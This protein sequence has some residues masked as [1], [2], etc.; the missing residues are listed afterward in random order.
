MT[1]RASVRYTGSNETA[2]LP[3]AELSTLLLLFSP[4]VLLLLLLLMLEL[5]E[6]DEE[7]FR[8]AAGRER[9][10]MDPPPKLMLAELIS[11]V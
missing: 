10:G 4:L 9:F 3:R 11:L 6:K 1:A 5:E 7:S 8:I 2:F